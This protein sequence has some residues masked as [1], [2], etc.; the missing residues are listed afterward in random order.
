MRTYKYKLNYNL[1]VAEY[2]KFL[3]PELDKLL[4]RLQFR[5]KL[6][7]YYRA[8]QNFNKLK[9]KQRLTLLFRL[10]QY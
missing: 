7:A 1:S 9:L 5:L 3:A 8:S 6:L 4:M 2:I 10:I